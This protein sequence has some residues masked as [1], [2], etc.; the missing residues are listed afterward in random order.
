MFSTGG[1]RGEGGRRF[2]FLSWTPAGFVK[3]LVGLFTPLLTVFQS[4]WK[5]SGFMG[6]T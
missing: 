2:L 4:D 1:P 3:N 6:R 5:E